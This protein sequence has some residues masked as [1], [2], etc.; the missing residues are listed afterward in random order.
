MMFLSTKNPVEALIP[1]EATNKD[2]T[3]DLC[4]N[5]IKMQVSLSVFVFSSSVTIAQK[6][7]GVKQRAFII[8]PS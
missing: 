7:H 4:V 8:S 6:L 3:M 1:K 2:E 5:T